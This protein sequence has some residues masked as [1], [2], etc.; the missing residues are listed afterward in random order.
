MMI[1]GYT[2]EQQAQER[3]ILRAMNAQHIKWAKGDKYDRMDAEQELERLKSQMRRL[4]E[5]FDQIS[6]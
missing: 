3:R 6:R 2:A 5:S 4:R 1:L